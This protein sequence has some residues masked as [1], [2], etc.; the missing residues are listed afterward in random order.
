MRRQA[1]NREN[2]FAN[3]I[4]DKELVSKIYK[5]HLKFSNKKKQLKK[6]KYLDTSPNKNTNDNCMKSPQLLMSLGN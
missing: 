6:E 3:H 5:E 2:T 1:T 4:S